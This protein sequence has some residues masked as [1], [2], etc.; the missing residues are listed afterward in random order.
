MFYFYI[1]LTLVTYPLVFIGSFVLFIFI[2]I[3]ILDNRYG[4]PNTFISPNTLYKIYKDN[5]NKWAKDFKEWHKKER[6]HDQNKEITVEEHEVYTRKM[7]QS[8]IAPETGMLIT[9]RYNH[10]SKTVTHSG[11][12]LYLSANHVI[13]DID[14]KEWHGLIG[15]YVV[16]HYKS[17]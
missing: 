6:L 15:D 7:Y 1:L 10:D 2:F 11:R 12:V 3:F 17:Y 4:T 16:E 8:S 13:L 5:I 9:V 14:G